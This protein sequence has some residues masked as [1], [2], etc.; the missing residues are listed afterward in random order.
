VIVNRSEMTLRPDM[1][2]L[3]YLLFFFS[4]F[5]ALVYQVVWVRVLGNVFGNT[6][7]SA[8]VVVAVFM[9]GLGVGG[10]AAGGWADRKYQT[11]PESL[12]RS[13]G[14]VELAIAALGFGLSLLLPQLGRLS[15][16]VSAYSLDEQGWHVIAAGSYLAQTGIAIVLLTPITMLMGATLTLLI[17]HLVQRDVDV[18]GSRIAVLYAVNTGG[19][20]LGCFLTDFAFVPSFGLRATQ[21]VAVLLN[22]V[23]GAGALLLATRVRAADGSSRARQSITRSRGS[24]KTTAAIPSSVVSIG[25]ALVLSGFAA[26]GMEIVWFRHFT[27]LLGQFRAVFSLLLTVILL[28]IGLG[29]LASGM[30]I[31]RLA[32]P[33]ESWAVVQALFVATSLFG[34]FIAD[35]APIEALVRPNPSLSSGL[36]PLVTMESGWQQTLAELWFNLRPMLFEVAPAALLMGFGFPLANAIVQRAEDSVGRR[37]GLLYLANTAGAVLGSLVTGLM[38]L[39]MLGVQGTATALM[40]VAASAL[41]PLFFGSQLDAR[42]SEPGRPHVRT[43]V[44]AASSLVAVTALALW[45]MLPSSHVLTRALPRPATNERQL[46]LKEGLNEV[47]AVTDI[48]DSGR[49]LLTNGHPMSSTTPTAQ[50]YMRAL[51]HIPLL[52][53]DN[54]RSALIIGFGVGN[55]TH[56]ASL[57]P[58]MERI[59]VADLSRDIL[60]SAGYFNDVNG[61]VLKDARV[62]VYVNDGRQHLHTVAPASFDLITLEPP[63]IAY[64][65]VAALY[66]REFYGLART[67]LKPGGYLSQ[68]L[69]AYQVP[70]TTTMA[71]IRAFIDVFPNAVLLSGA[72]SELILLGAN[73]M[74]LEINPGRLADALSRAPTVQADLRRLDLGSPTEIIGT[75]LGSSQTLA[76]ATREVPPVTDDRPNQEYG[77]LSLLNLGQAVPSAVIDLSTVTAWC[78]SCFV[79]G[80][81][82]VPVQGLDVYLELLRQAY[83]ASPEAVRQ[84]RAQAPPGGRIVAGSKYL[85]SIVPESAQLH[86]VL[87]LSQASAGNM[88]VAIREFREA[89]RLDPASATTHWHLGAALASHGAPAEALAHLQRSVALD[90]SNEAAHNDVGAVLLRQGRVD[91][92]INHFDQALALNPGFTE[93]RANLDVAIRVRR[94]RPSN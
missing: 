63:P 19:A 34:L 92:A 58:T 47:V 83:T 77:V 38:L 75:F 60:A 84:A 14:Y 70:T 16:L 31:R 9:L 74:R 7:Y 17:R 21:I 55:T 64:A 48:P 71:M 85:G 41:I 94:Q 68:W 40:A 6:I 29:A 69:P 24:R 65:G 42:G 4:G 27:I 88:E 30:L 50:R 80:Q 45:V 66:S 32:R 36:A 59:E 93:A 53:M 79:N 86:N 89:L 76:T 54:P 25:V 35:A 23:A 2:G 46:A 20:A 10:F 73:A 11:R 3:L 13:Y 44:F 26:M 8:A 49:R 51:A 5:S 61:D 22:L 90:P 12:L 91:E 57:H 56:A 37:A 28:G 15:S 33:V 52:S 72:D 87:A 39:A 81:P 1:T 78:P 18:S 43:T 67:R 82:T 62:S